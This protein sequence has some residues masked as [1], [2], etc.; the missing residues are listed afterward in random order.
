MM[1]IRSAPALGACLALLASAAAAATPANGVWRTTEDGGQVEI[2][3][4]DGA[5]TGRLLTSARL[6]ANPGQLDERNADPARRTRT[7]KGMELFAGMTGKAPLWR[8]RVYNPADGKTYSGS[9]TLVNATAL[10]LTGCV[11]AVFCRSQTWTRLR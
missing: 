1:H 8:G 9:V 3:D 10:K 2:S 5:I 7:L 11:A 6:A 4:V